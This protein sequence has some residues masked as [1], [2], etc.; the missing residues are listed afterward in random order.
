MSWNAPGVSVSA[1]VVV[2]GPGL[3]GRRH[4]VR[5][6]SAS[7]PALALDDRTVRPR[8]KR[9]RRLSVSEPGWG[10]GVTAK[11]RP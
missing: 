9:K 10:Q 2:V 4:S 11:L 3:G 7:A 6:P 8:L 5:R 1:P